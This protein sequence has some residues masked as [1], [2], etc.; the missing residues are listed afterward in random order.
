MESM[1]QPPTLATVVHMLDFMQPL[2]EAAEATVRA[3]AKK[4]A[5]RKRLRRGATVRPGSTTPLWNEVV[6]ATRPFLRKYGEKAIL[7]RLLGVPRQRIHD[8]FV[9][10]TAYPDAERVLLL[11]QW[12][13]ARRAGKNPA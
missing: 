2:A 11:L 4:Y 1:H 7:A 10:R 9:S 13:A 8:Y 3:A 12:L 6:T 5:A